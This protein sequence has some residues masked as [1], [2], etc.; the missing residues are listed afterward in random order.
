LARGLA[1]G[2]R[3]ELAQKSVLADALEGRREF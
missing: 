2:S 3:L 1:S